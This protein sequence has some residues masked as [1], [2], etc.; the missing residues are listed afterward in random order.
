[1]LLCSITLAAWVAFSGRIALS[2][3]IGG[4]ISTVSF[5]WLK[6]DIHKIFQGSLHAAKILYFVKYFARLAI[7]AI[8]LYWLVK[9]ERVDVIGLL[10]GLSSIV[11]SIVITALSASRKVHSNL[12]EAS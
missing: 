1:M 9:N 5:N 12:K 3:L 2:I 4:V 8:I 6:K 11:L 7:I 10:G